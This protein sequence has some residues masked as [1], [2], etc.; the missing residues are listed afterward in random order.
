MSMTEI[1]SDN[2]ARRIAALERLVLCPRCKGSGTMETPRGDAT[3]ISCEGT[4]I[5]PSIYNADGATHD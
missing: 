4:T 2:H 3:C 1:Q 5:N